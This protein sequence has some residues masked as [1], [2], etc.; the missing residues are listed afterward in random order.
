MTTVQD[1]QLRQAI[2][3]T[4]AERKA[5]AQRYL[6]YAETDYAVESAELLYTRDQYHSQLLDFSAAEGFL[7]LG[8]QHG[9]TKATFIEQMNHYGLVCQPGQYLQRW[10]TEYAKALVQTLNPHTV[11]GR[12]MKVYFTTDERRAMT[13][14][15]TIAHQSQIIDLVTPYGKLLDPTTTME[16]VAHARANGSKIIVD[17]T[18]T[19]FGRTGK[20]W[21]HQRWDFHPDIVVVG[22]PAGGGF[23]FGAVIAPA[24]L[25]TD[26]HNRHQLTAG[27]PAVCAA[28]CATLRAIDGPVLMH[29][30]DSFFG[31][32]DGLA[33]LKG[34]FPEIIADHIGVGLLHFLHFHSRPEALQFF[35]AAHERGLML[36]PPVSKVITLTPPL[37][38]SELEQRRGIDLLAS[39]CLEWM[40]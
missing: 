9:P 16:Q 22:G 40:Y 29:V 20:F 1:A 17:E 38:T 12:E 3:E 23:P 13:F 33:S 10:P 26:T 28:G 36:T 37:I 27:H 31:F 39:V 2:D 35:H 34:Q 8:H 30:A 7:P 24:E 11:Q 5:D 6:A 4:L 21:G 14:A 19:G 32:N 15:L 18:Y 25:F